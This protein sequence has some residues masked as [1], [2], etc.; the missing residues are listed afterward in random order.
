MSD[1]RPIAYRE[2]QDNGEEWSIYRVSGIGGCITSLIAA[3]QGRAAVMEEWQERILM[4]AA[5]SGNRLE[6]VILGLLGELGYRIVE[7][8]SQDE[9]MLKVIPRVYLRGH[10]DGRGFVARGRK[11]H[12]VEI[13]TMSSA[14]FKKWKALGGGDNGARYALMD[15]EFKKYGW[16]VACQMVGAAVGKDGKIDRTPAYLPAIY[17][18]LDRDTWDKAVRNGEEYNLTSILDVSII[19]SLPVDWTTIKRKVMEAE[20]WR[21]KYPSFPR[22]EGEGGERS[23]C[24]YS[25]MHDEDE[26][27]G[28]FGAEDAEVDWPAVSVRDEQ[29]A[30]M[31]A[32]HHQLTARMRDGEA[33]ESERKL[34]NPKI[35]HVLGVDVSDGGEGKN[36]EWEGAGYR[37]KS[38]KGGSA[39]RVD[40]TALYRAM[41][42]RGLIDPGVL[43]FSQWAALW[44]ELT[45]RNKYWYPQVEKKN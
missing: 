38:R 25:Y 41:E 42:D 5:D 36:V 21:N 14:R 27:E 7:G 43:G 8:S 19:D 23:F 32:V 26:D 45:P 3:I 18:V 17:A 44:D 16:Q 37:V 34:L 12:V 33:A 40:K 30:G 24:S 6:P 2:Q 10:L 1:N 31:A 13:K 39:G 35:L 28:A 22:C 11:Q 20:R 4:P 9:I 15:S 29:L